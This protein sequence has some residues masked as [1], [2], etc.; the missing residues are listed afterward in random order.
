MNGS[1]P[2]FVFVGVAFAIL[3]VVLA[4][5]VVVGWIRHRHGRTFSDEI[6][7]AAGMAPHPLNVP[8]RRGRRRRAAA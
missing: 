3:V 5:A 8:G 6:E 1:Y 4:L 2:F 7:E